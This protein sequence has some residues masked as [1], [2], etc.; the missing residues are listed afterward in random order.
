MATPL[1]STAPP[2]ASWK[3]RPG[4]ADQQN[5]WYAARLK[6]CDAF[7]SAGSEDALV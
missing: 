4:H 1:S 2:F 5:A 6:V 3:F 7:A